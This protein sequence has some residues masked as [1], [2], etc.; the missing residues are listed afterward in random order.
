MGTYKRE[1]NPRQ[2]VE[3]GRAAWSSHGISEQ[4]ALEIASKYTWAATS[5]RST[6]P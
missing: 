1:A 3:R 6:A 2:I 5:P 4:E